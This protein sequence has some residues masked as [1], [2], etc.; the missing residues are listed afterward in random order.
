MEA[1]KGFI[2]IIRLSFTTST[3]FLYCSF[4]DFNSFSLRISLLPHNLLDIHDQPVAK[5]Y[6]SVVSST[7]EKSRCALL[8]LRY[9]ANRCR[10]KSIVGSIIQTM[11]SV[12]LLLLSIGAVFVAAD[13]AAAAAAGG[14]PDPATVRYTFPS[15]FHC[16]YC[17]SFVLYFVRFEHN[18]NVI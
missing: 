2:T 12:A 4:Y 3:S 5:C 15:Q 1:D 14:L 16:I 11:R 6:S 17:I 9:S 8:I 18:K 13:D 10:L 7:I